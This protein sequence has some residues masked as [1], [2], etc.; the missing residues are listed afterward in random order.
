VPALYVFTAA[1]I[2]LDLLILKPKYTWPGM[3]IVLA[4]IPLYFLW[5]KVSD[6]TGSA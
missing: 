2:C 5:R 4:G 3:L 1:A 6:S